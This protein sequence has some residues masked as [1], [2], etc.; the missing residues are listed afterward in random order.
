[1][2]INGTD[3][4]SLGL[5]VRSTS[6]FFDMP[7]RLSP[8]EY[9]WGDEIQP[10]LDL[11]H[12]AFKFQNFKVKFV[13]DSRVTSNTLAQTITYLK[14]LGE[15]TLSQ[16]DASNGNGEFLVWLTSTSEEKK[17]S[18]VL[19]SVTVNFYYRLPVFEATLPTAFNSSESWGGYS[20]S[21]FGLI[22]SEKGDFNGV[23]LIY[24]SKETTYMSSAKKVNHR[25]LNQVSLNCWIIASDYSDLITKVSQFKKLSSLHGEK[26]LNHLGQ[27]FRT[28]LTDGFKC[29]QV[30]KRAVKFTLKLNVI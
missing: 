3:T 28:Y 2:K 5:L 30:G 17:L 8:T 15:F 29:T 19:S 6:G 9:D 20:F 18:N 27:T 12:M 11:E 4:K 22:V 13:Y 26:E 21:Q 14:S 10:L 25:A 24:D 23:G 1:M 16:T 7:E